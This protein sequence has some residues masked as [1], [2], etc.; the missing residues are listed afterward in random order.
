SWPKTRPMEPPTIAVA[1]GLVHS[2]RCT[3][4][5][6]PGRRQFQRLKQA[7]ADEF[8]P[9]LAGEPFESGGHDQIVRAIV[10]G[11]R[12]GREIRSPAKNSG[13]KLAT[14]CGNS[15]AGKCRREREA[16]QMIAHPSRMGQGLA[17]GDTFPSRIDMRNRVSKEFLEGRIPP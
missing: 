1:P 4:R 8:L 11:F 17:Y 10:T 13:R 16:D 5:A 9:S 7:L 6:E 2:T 12:A 14:L 3:G 15:I